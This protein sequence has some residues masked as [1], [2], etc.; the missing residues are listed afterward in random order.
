MLLLISLRESDE[1]TKTD[2]NIGYEIM[3]IKLFFGLQRVS[4]FP[5]GE[6]PH[7]ALAEVGH[8]LLREWEVL[9]SP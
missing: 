1:A 6:L 9:L 4:E 5:L 7:H 3:I 8:I 2:K